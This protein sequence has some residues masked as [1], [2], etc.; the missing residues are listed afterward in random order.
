MQVINSTPWE[1]AVDDNNASIVQISYAGEKTD[2]LKDS[3][4]LIFPEINSNENLIDKLSW[5]VV[6]KGDST[7]SLV[8]IDTEE[9]Y[10]KFPYHFNLM[11][12]YALDGPQ[13]NVSFFLKNNSPKQMKETLSFV[14]PFNLTEKEALSKKIILDNDQYEVTIES[15]EFD[16][17][18]HNNDVVCKLPTIN[19]EAQ[20]ELKAALSI[21]L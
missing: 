1:V 2:L 16:L 6:D 17:Q 4:K 3:T 18:S 12:T 5:T 20:A 13:L 15:N 19:L 9:S 10:R 14:L 7:V 8:M 21:I 11:V